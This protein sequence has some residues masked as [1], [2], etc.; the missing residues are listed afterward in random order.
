MPEGCALSLMGDRR[1]L[2]YRGSVAK[3][4]YLSMRDFNP[5]ATK[6][7]AGKGRENENIPS[8]FNSAVGLNRIGV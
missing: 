6:G 4:R 5:V 1:A 8:I 3:E 7:K 2:F